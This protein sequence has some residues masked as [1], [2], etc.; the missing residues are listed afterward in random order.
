MDREIWWEN[1]EWDT[2]D[3][4]LPLSLS[5]PSSGSWESTRMMRSISEAGTPI[6]KLKQHSY[7]LSHSSFQLRWHLAYDNT[8]HLIPKKL[9]DDSGTQKQKCACKLNSRENTEFI[10]IHWRATKHSVCTGLILW[11]PIEQNQAPGFILCKCS[12]SQN[13]YISRNIF[14]GFFFTLH[15]ESIVFI[16]LQLP[17][18]VLDQRQQYS[19][20]GTPQTL[21]VCA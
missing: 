13:F 12:I 15:I 3:V 21:L 4:C 18:R 11:P 9:D 20:S 10:R 16:H 17:L 19:C 14:L 8:H 2:R 6:W 7:H 5:W 1:D